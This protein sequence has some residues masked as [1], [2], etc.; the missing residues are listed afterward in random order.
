ML[1]LENLLGARAAAMGG[2]CSP[3]TTMTVPCDDDGGVRNS[4]LHIMISTDLAARGFDVPN[5]SHV[6]NFDLQSTGMED[7]MLMCTGVDVQAGWAG[8]AR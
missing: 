1:R 2:F 3:P 8:G 4:K 6:I 5:V 7:K